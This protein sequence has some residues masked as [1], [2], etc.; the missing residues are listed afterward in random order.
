MNEGFPYMGVGEGLSPPLRYVYN[1]YIYIYI[2]MCIYI[3]IYN[4]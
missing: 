1:I 3:Y 4:I 2:Y